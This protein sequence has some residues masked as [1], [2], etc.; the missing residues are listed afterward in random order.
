MHWIY[1]IHEFLN[2]SWITEINKLFHDILI[3]WD[4]PVN[5]S[6]ELK[7]VLNVLNVELTGN[8]VWKYEKW[9]VSLDFYKPLFVTTS[10]APVGL[11]WTKVFSGPKPLAD[12]PNEAPWRLVQSLRLSQL[13][14]NS[15]LAF[16][17]TVEIQLRMVSVGNIVVL[18]YIQWYFVYHNTA[19]KTN[20]QDLNLHIYCIEHRFCGVFVWLADLHN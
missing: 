10:Q 9:A 8:L 19:I 14:H 12:G 15:T 16:G 7:M 20:S 3:Y 13:A 6:S 18:W 5:V 2:L 17:L 11:L 1:L 4:A